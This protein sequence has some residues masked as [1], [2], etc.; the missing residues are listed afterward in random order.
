MPKCLLSLIGQ[1][2]QAL[3]AAVEVAGATAG[4]RIKTGDDLD[5]WEHRLKSP[6]DW[7]EMLTASLR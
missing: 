2:A 3:T 7:A 5:V 4:D 1:E 6:H